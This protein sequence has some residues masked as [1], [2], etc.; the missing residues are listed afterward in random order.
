MSHQPSKSNEYNMPSIE[1]NGEQWIRL[2]DHVVL[3]EKAVEEGWYEALQ[4]VQLILG[5]KSP[6]TVKELIDRE[7]DL[8]TP[9]D[10]K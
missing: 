5:Y 6:A 4:W 8:L 10:T 2:I 7:L 3:T 9:K 1:Y